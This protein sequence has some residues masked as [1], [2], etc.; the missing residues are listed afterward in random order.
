MAD[1]MTAATVGNVVRY[2]GS[3]F[4]RWK[5][6][7]ELV[8][9]WA[10]VL[11]RYEEPVARRVIAEHRQKRRGDDPS[12]PDLKEALEDAVPGVLALPQ[13]ASANPADLDDIGGWLGYYFGSEQGRR[14][15]AGLETKAQTGLVWMRG[16]WGIDEQGR[17]V[18]KATKE[19]WRNRRMQA[20]QAAA[21]GAA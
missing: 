20:L 21:G 2:L 18:D 19:Q 6:T 12:L 14:E 11:R 8:T 9:L 15:F 3:L 4:P 7:P 13:R 5:T 10:D 17:R 1:R 16:I